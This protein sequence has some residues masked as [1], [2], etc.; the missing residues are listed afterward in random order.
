MAEPME[1]PK[2]KTADQGSPA[3]TAPEPAKIEITQA[4]YQ[5][6]VNDAAEYKDKFVRLFADFD[7]AR[8]RY[9]RDR[10]EFIRY[11]HEGIIME[12]LGI[13][14]DLERSVAAAKAVP[15]D[16]QS[17]LKG[18]EMVVGRI[19]ELLKR[20]DVRSMD[21]VGKKF[22]PHCHEILMM[23]ESTGH[24]EDTVIEE[25]QKGY[26]LADKV[27][28]TAKVKV[29]KPGQATAGEPSNKAS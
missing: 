5:K 28:R 12:F 14:D 10:A 11:A 17:L 27:I 26:F 19:H 13:L 4:E 21:C 24:N 20:N 18:I 3:E 7:N 9:D 15:Q 6:F 16:T 25:F 29:A 1:N 8:K 22:D 2:P 23:A